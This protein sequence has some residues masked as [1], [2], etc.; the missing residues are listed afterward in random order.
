MLKTLQFFTKNI[1]RL[2]V[3]IPHRY[4]ENT[5]DCHNNPYQFVVSIPHRYAENG[6]FLPGKTYISMFQSLIGMLKTVTASTNSAIHGK[7]QSLIGMLKTLHQEN[8]QMS[9]CR[10]QSLIGMLKTSQFYYHLHHQR[11]VSIPHRY[12]ENVSA[13]L[14]LTKGDTG[15]NP[16]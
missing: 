4:A 3:S 15:F 13:R 11:Q 2:E 16:S 10:F 5:A 8:H 6:S 9:H 7:F 12:A 14:V 1:W